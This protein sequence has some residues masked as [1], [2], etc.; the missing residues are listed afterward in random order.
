[1]DDKI[2]YYEFYVH[3]PILA[4]STGFSILSE[5][6]ALR[7]P[8]LHLISWGLPAL[9]TVVALSLGH[10]EGDNVSGLCNLGKAKINSSLI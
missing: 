1:M 9:K 6:I 8:N 10:V 3:R 2:L 4:I 7:A 5:A